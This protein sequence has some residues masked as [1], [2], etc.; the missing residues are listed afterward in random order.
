M[1]L[2]A[3]VAIIA[4]SIWQQYTT[5]TLSIAKTAIIPPFGLF[6]YLFMPFGLTNAAQTFQRLMDRLFGH[7]PFVFTYLDDHLVASATMEEHLE[8]LRIFFEILRDNGLTINPSKCSF[9][10]S[11]VKFLGHM[12]SESGVVPLPRHVEAITGFPRHT[13]L[14]QLQRFLGLIN[15]YRRF[16]PAIAG[17]L[18][19][20]T[21]LLRGAPKKLLW[22][23]D[24]DAAFTKAKAAL[25]A[26]VPL[27]HPAPGA[28]LS[29]A[30]DASDTHVGGVLQQLE[31]AM[32][33]V[34]PPWSARQQRQMAYLAEFTADFRHTPGATNV[35]A[36][37]LSWP[38]A[39]FTGAPPQQVPTSQI[40]PPAAAVKTPVAA[41]PSGPEKTP[42]RPPHSSD[43][44]A[45]QE[46]SLPE[47]QTHT[48]PAA[49]PA[50]APVAPVAA[51]Q[52]LN[53]SKIAA[54]QSSC[55][56]VASMRAST[57]LSIV[58]KPMGEHQLLGDVIA[59]A[60]SAAASSASLRTTRQTRRTS[61]EVSLKPR[62]L[63]LGGTCGRRRHQQRHFI[64]S[65]VIS[66]SI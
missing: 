55:P 47:S 65:S 57:A 15:F 38:S 64:S 58:S 26:A 3:R 9:A 8:H 4:G 25:V 18:K 11:S 37:A 48:P 36:D 17:I 43:A 23:S 66:C 35:V 61:A 42:P 41:L 12:V 50:T 22:S 14:R 59:A 56:D 34:S 33:R 20:L 53:F 62:R 24:A 29:L 45:I 39:P 21:D 7:L 54:A 52:P 10:V 31:A 28:V 27:S 60:G 30:V 6:E 46:L 49:P 2:G 19:L 5:G 63:G 40:L 32:S 16:L 1:D 51:A 13:D 44:S